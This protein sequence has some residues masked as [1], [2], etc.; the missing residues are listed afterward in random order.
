MKCNE[1]AYV[2]TS[3]FLLR[4]TNIKLDI[5]SRGFPRIGATI[6]SCNIHKE[7]QIC[8]SVPKTPL[9]GRQK[10]FDLLSFLQAIK[11]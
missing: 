7:L 8:Y 1:I 11:R 5:I 3:F 6:E 9:F 4:N 2:L 10:E